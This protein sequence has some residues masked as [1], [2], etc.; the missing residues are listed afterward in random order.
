MD[1][2]FLT[3][4]VVLT[5]LQVINLVL[6][7]RFREERHA[8][9]RDEAMARLDAKVNRVLEVAADEQLMRSE[10]LRKSVRLL[11]QELRNDAALLEE[12]HFLRLQEVER[13]IK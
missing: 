8:M 13:L 11:V 3:W 5:A 1:L 6:N 7:L 9:D 12:R 2:F 10:K 4:L